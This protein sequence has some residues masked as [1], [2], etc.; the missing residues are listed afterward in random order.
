[1][2]NGG[3]FAIGMLVGVLITLLYFWILEKLQ[4]YIYLI[5]MSFSSFINYR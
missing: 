5:M 3:A 1:M 2:T 4:G